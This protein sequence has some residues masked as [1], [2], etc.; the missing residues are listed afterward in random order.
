MWVATQDL[1]RTAGQPFYARLN[2][3]L[4]KHDV[5]RRLRVP[6]FSPKSPGTPERAIVFL[7]EHDDYIIAEDFE[8]TPDLHLCGLMADEIRADGSGDQVAT[9]RSGVAVSLPTTCVSR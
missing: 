5:F 8:D 2:Q 6:V 4:D 3:V 1:P 7:I 9:P